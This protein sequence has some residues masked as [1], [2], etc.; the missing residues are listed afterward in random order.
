MLQWLVLALSA[1]FQA[2]ATPRSAYDVTTLKIG[3]PVDGRRTRSRPPEG[4]PSAGQLVAGRAWFYIQTAEG[5]PQ[6]PKLHHYGLQSR[7]AQ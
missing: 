3:T 1:L 2:S 5:N 4:R 7:V 6:S